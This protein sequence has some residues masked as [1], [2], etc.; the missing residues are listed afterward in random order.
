MKEGFKGC[1]LSLTAHIQEKCSRV[2][3]VLS[4]MCNTFASHAVCLVFES[5]PRQT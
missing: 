5:Q 4:T 2:F 1:A 3:N